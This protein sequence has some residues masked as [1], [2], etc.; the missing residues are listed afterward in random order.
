MYPPDGPMA[1]LPGAE[2]L[3]SISLKLNQYAARRLM[4][5]GI[6]DFSSNCRH[7]IR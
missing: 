2:A 3:F 4:L 1:P 7:L 6:F 5:A